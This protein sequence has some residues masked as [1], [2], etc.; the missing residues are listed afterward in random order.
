MKCFGLFFPAA[1]ARSI[2]FFAQAIMFSEEVTG[3][4]ALKMF[5]MKSWN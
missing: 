4:E 2:V 5:L 1:A 3:A